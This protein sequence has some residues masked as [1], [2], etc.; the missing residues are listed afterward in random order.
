MIR[1]S[2]RRAFAAP[3]L[4]GCALPEPGRFRVARLVD[5]DGGKLDEALI[6]AMKGPKSSTGEDIV[7]IHAHGSMAVTAAIIRRLGEAEGFRPAGP[8]EFTHRMFANGKI[9]LLGA[10]ALADLIDAETDRLGSLPLVG[11]WTLDPIREMRTYAGSSGAA[12]C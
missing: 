2:G 10:E 6:L 8:G 9:D 11:P 1:I 5:G 12:C 7:E 3:A 4:F